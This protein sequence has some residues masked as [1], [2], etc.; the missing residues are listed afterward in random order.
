MTGLLHC[1]SI[2]K[3]CLTGSLILICYNHRSQSVV[4]KISPF[5]TCYRTDLKSLPIIIG[6]H[7]HMVI[8][9]RKKTSKKATACKAGHVKE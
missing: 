7:N 8:D 6:I 2:E 4:M 9:L 3:S 1:N 5:R